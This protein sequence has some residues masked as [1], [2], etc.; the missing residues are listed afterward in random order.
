MKN[1]STIKT[2]LDYLKKYWFL[3]I[4]SL[5]FAAGSVVLSLSI[6]IFIGNGIDLILGKDNVDFEKLLP[7]LTNVGIIALL[8]GFLQWLMNL[9]NN[10]ITYNVTKDIRNRAFDK[11][12]TL[13]LSYIDSHPSGETVNKIISDV[14]QFAEGL[15]MGF[16]QF[17]S[18]IV[19]ILCTLGIMFY[20]SWK[21]ALVVF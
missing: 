21:I 4:I 10:R 15:L 12:H 3:I 2:V 18:G 9:I 1:L 6:P 16:T 13:P 17:F 19:T 14:D 7:I 5:I 20:L 8:V 11:I